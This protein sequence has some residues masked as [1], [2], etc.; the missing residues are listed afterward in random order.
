[1][2]KLLDSDWLKAA[3]FKCKSWL[4]LAERQYKMFKA[5]DITYN[6]DENF[7]RKLSKRFLE[8]EKG[9]WK[10]LEHFLYANYF[11]FILYFK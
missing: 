1:M 6:D 9:F 5:N 11:M 2:K 10:D 7:V 8:W 4:W 3:Q